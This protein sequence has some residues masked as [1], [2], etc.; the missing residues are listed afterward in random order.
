MEGLADRLTFY[1]GPERWW[2]RTR[3]PSRTERLIR[4]LRMRRRLMGAIAHPAAA[5]RAVFGPLARW[6]LLP[7]MTHKI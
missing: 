3:T 4:P 7:E 2:R 1:P 5:H 6:H